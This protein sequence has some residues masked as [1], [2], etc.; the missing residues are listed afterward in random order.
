MT[1]IRIEMERDECDLKPAALAAQILHE[2]FLA[3][4]K[5]AAYEAD[6]AMAMEAVERPLRLFEMWFKFCSVARLSRQGMRLYFGGLEMPADILCDQ[7]ARRLEYLKLDHIV[8]MAGMGPQDLMTLMSRF[9]VR[10]PGIITAR[11]VS[12]YLEDQHVSKIRA[13]DAEWTE[14]RIRERLFKVEDASMLTVSSLVMQKC[15]KRLDLVASVVSGH[16]PSAEV[17]IRRYGCY[18]TPEILNRVLP[19]SFTRMPVDRLIQ[20]VDEEIGGDRSELQSLIESSQRYDYLR[21]LIAAFDNHPQRRDLLAA[22]R[23]LFHRHGMSDAA[24]Q[25]FDPDGTTQPEPLGEVD[26]HL[27]KMFSSACTPADL[28]GFGMSFVRVLREGSY[29]KP[30]EILS[31]LLLHLKRDDRAARRKAHFALGRG[32]AAAGA[33]EHWSVIGW[34][35][36][37]LTEDVCSGEDTFEFSDLLGGAGEQLV[38]AGRLDLLSEASRKLRATIDDSASPADDLVAQ[39]VLKRWGDPRIVSELIRVVTLEAKPRRGY[40]LSALAAIGGSEVA[41]RA[42]SL[43]THTNRAIRVT[44]LK[45]LSELGNEAVEVCH[46]LLSADDLWERADGQSALPDSSW[47]TVRNAMNILGSLGDPAAIPMLNLHMNDADPRVRLEVVRALEKMED[48]DAL[49][50]LLSMTEDQNLDVSCS[51]VMAMGASGGEHEVFVLQELFGSDALK[52]AKIIQ[53]IGHIGGAQAKLFLFDLL[54][55]DEGFRK[56]GLKNEMVVLRKDVL[57]ALAINPDAEIIGHIERYCRDHQ[58]TFRIPIARGAS[59]ES[60][61]VKME[62]SRKSTGKT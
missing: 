58:V 9:T 11:W 5:V 4:K 3:V 20:L 30:K 59:S 39:A 10:N 42:A 35:A 33:T 32:L 54:D 50:T 23:R 48:P 19:Q 25:V 47:Y 16:T 41:R 24:Y 38:S 22:S 31:S 29:E 49:S 53:A 21:K 28:D 40:A 34:F 8:F 26:E 44:M 1:D 61:V 13:N 2:L 62:R 57:R 12:Q 15:G 36:N 7:L 43:V 17:L 6:N 18:Y 46:D 51:A 37:R 52:S 55:D 27:L 56:A 60:S 14:T 45:L